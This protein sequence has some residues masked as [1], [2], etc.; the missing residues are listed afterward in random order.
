MTQIAQAV[1]MWFKENVEYKQH[2][3]TW[4]AGVLWLLYETKHMNNNTLYFAI[5]V[6]PKGNI[7]AYQQTEEPFI[8]SWFPVAI[9]KMRKDLSK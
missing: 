6:S 2:M 7:L 9:E 5:G 4:E 3:R 8:R 1:E